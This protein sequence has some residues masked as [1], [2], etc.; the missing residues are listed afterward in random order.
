MDNAEASGQLSLTEAVIPVASLILLVGLSYY[1][2][3]DA[4]ASGPNQVALVVATMI[5]VLVARRRGH[6]LQSLS[7]A[8]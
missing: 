8:A 7:D 4:G 5:A 6:D 2:F 1:L 3:G